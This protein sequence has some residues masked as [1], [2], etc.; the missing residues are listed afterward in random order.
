[1]K[2]SVHKMRAK[3]N[4]HKAG[5]IPYFSHTKAFVI[6]IA[7][8]YAGIYEKNQNMGGHLLVPLLQAY[9]LPLWAFVWPW[10]G[11]ASTRCSS[12]AQGPGVVN[13]VLLMHKKYN[14]T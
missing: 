9:A 14:Q 11:S 4:S 3:R 6:K 12:D 8:G 5:Y 7:L 1:V 2:I 13:A 10:P